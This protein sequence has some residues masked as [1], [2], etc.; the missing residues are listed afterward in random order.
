MRKKVTAPRNTVIKGQPH[1]LAYINDQEQGLLM[2][3]GGAGVPVH[4]IPAYYGDGGLGGDDVGDG[5]TSDGNVGSDT[6]SG[7]G[8]NEN[9]GFSPAEIAA[10][11]AARDAIAAHNAA[12]MAG[13]RPNESNAVPNQFFTNDYVAN[14]LAG[15]Q[16]A[17]DD[18]IAK[19]FFDYASIMA[20]SVYSS[21]SIGG[22]LK[23]LGKAS[24]WADLF[25]GKGLNIGQVPSYSSWFD[26]KGVR[27]SMA[28]MAIDQVQG[29]SYGDGRLGQAVGIASGFFNDKVVEALKNGGR[30]VLDASG[31][32]M[33][34]FTQGPYGLGEVYTGLP[35]EGLPETGWVDPTANQEGSIKP[36]NELTGTCEAGYIY[37]EDLK[38]CRLDTGSAPS[39]PAT[40]NFGVSGETYYRPNALDN[41]PAN[42][43]AYMGPNYNYNQANKNF[44][45]TYA[46]NPDYYENQMDITGFA[47]VS[48]IL[49]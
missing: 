37:D 34:A 23:N 1:Q 13:S 36:V 20:P 18:Q 19:S 5:T 3:L 47:P 29:R 42:I 33:G 49:I 25:S 14:M 26:D 31:K 40:G 4:G 6:G 27:S 45:Q 44:V 2:A 41:A 21:Q 32:V 35:V 38:A 24:T 30:P 39:G 46:Y 8:D 16:K 22:D 12:V 43:P 7:G 10:G 15:Q 28:N 48:G 11:Q 17:L 9:I